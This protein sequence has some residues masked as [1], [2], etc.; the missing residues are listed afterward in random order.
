V[1]EV[2]LKGKLLALAENDF[3]LSKGEDLDALLAAMMAHIGSL[4]PELRD[5][6]IYV[7][8][9]NLIQKKPVVSAEQL[10]VLLDK[11]LSDEGMFYQLGDPEGDGVF[12]RAFSVLLLPLILISHRNQPFLDMGEVM[13]VQEGLLR[14]MRK[15]QDRRGFVDGKGWAHAI[16]HGADALDDLAQCVEVDRDG[17]REILAVVQTAVCIQDTVYTHGEDDRL[18]TPVIA[19]LRRELLAEDEMVRWVEGFTD[20]VTSV[21]GMPQRMYIQ[22]NVSNFLQ[23]L[24]FRLGWADLSGPLGA[25]I[26]GTL[27]KMNRFAGN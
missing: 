11:A 8:F 1:N 16:A 12:T 17:L 22:S 5:E 23:S 14:F 13:R 18:V 25:A 20:A 4:D 27:R 7:G 3:Q 19:I 9:Y 2:Q 15:E 21:E 6:L 10:K 26:T 24:Y